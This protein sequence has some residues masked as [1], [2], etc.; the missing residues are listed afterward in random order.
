MEKIN[1]KNVEELLH[2]ILD[3][4][5]AGLIER[6]KVVRK[7]TPTSGAIYLHKSLIGK[8]YDVYFIPKDEVSTVEEEVKKV[9]EKLK[10]LKE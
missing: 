5:R 8:K 7:C 1:I 9:E 2:L 6:D 3:L 10:E 4:F